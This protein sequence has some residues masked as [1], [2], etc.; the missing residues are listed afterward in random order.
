MGGSIPALICRSVS[1]D[2]YHFIKDE[3]FG[4]AVS[5]KPFE[6]FTKLENAVIPCESV[7]K[8]AEWN[9]KI[10]FAGFKRMDG[11]AGSMTFMAARALGDGELIFEDL[12]F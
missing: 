1:T 7:P 11:Y 6:D 5:D 4:F 8:G 12:S 3:N 10:I 2:R 9:G